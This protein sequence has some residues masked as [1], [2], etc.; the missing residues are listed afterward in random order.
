MTHWKGERR[1]GGVGVWWDWIQMLPLPLIRR[2]TL[3]KKLNLVEP[4][5][6]ICEMAQQD[7]LDFGDGERIRE[8]ACGPHKE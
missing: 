5:F 2:G 6:P 1:E 7:H 8:T 3:G 4:Q